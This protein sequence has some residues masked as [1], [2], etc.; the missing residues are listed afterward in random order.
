MT[1]SI[2]ARCTRTR[3]FG[4]A[5]ASSSPAVAARCAHARTGTGAVATQNITDP[6]L[7]PRILDVLARGLPADEAL[8]E[9]LQST[10]FGAYRQ[11]VV[12][13]GQGPPAIHSGAH[14]LGL[15]G[16]AIG[17]HSAAAGN[18]LAR[19]DVPAAMVSAF[20]SAD[21]HLGARLLR[22]L[23]AGAERGGEAGPVHSAGLLVVGEVSWPIVD[24]RVDWIDHDPLGALAAAWDIYAPQIDDYVRRALDPAAAPSFGV[25]GNP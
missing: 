11:L 4:V 20:E 19:G 22:A 25:P 7:G 6:A 1:F 15:A 18:L 3:M 21:G 23:R 12:V 2:A 24:L 9:A 5:I 10:P 13:S 16:S 8:Q 17:A 14:A